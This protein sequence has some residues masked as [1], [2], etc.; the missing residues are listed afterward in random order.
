MRP[1]RVAHCA[2]VWLRRLTLVTGWGLVLLV[3]AGLVALWW[4]TATPGGVQWGVA[5]A[6]R[7]L[8]ALSVDEVTGTPWR[9]LRV[10]G[11]G[12]E[13]EEGASMHLE[14]GSL[15]IDPGALWRARL[16]IPE[17]TLDGI[18]L[19]LPPVTDEGETE[20]RG[21]LPAIPAMA[22]DIER[23]LAERVVIRQGETRYELAEARL[24]AQLE[25]RDQPPRVTTRLQALDLRLPDALRVNG[26]GELSVGLEGAIPVTARLELLIDHP[27]GWLDGPVTVAGSLRKGMSLRPRL[28][29]VGAD[30]ARAAV[31]GQ[32]TADAERLA[33]ES[34][35]VDALGGQLDLRGEAR[36]APSWSVDLT[37]EARSLDPTWIEPSLPGSLDFV[38]EAQVEAADG[39]LPGRGRVVLSDLQGRLAGEA[40][41]NVTLELRGDEARAS[42]RLSGTAAGGQLHFDGRLTPERTFDAE[43]QIDAL[44]VAMDDEARRTVRLASRGRLDG[45]LPDWR[46]E[47]TLDDWVEASRARLEDARLRLTEHVD[48][49]AERSTEIRLAGQLDSGRLAVEQLALAAPGAELSV[50]GAVQ[51]SPDWAR[52]R[53]E[54]VEASASVPNLAELPWDLIA[55]LPGVDPA[56]LRPQ[57]ARGKLTAMLQADG[58]LL[59]PHGRI[60]LQADR[61]RLAG[62]ALDRAR[63]DMRLDR[64]STDATS[65]DARAVRL[66]VEANGLRSTAGGSTLFDR[67]VVEADGRRADHRWTIELKDAADAGLGAHLEARGGWQEGAWQGQISRLT[68]E[69]PWAGG[70]RL[71][72]QA[73]L[74]LSPAAQRVDDLCL[75][76]M[77]V[78]PET[79]RADAVCLD[80]ERRD[81]HLQAS[82]Q[83]DLAL[84]DLWGQWRAGEADGA[85]FAGRLQ[86]DGEADI[87]G[88]ERT[89][90]LSLRLPASE[91]RLKPMGDDQAEP[92]VVTY[93]ETRLAATLAGERVEADLVGGVEDWL[94]IA[95]Q[96][97]LALGDRSVDGRLSLER[98][99]LQRL[100]ALVDR[101]F[102]P[103][104]SPVSELTGEVGGQLVLGG[105]LD[106]PRVS[107]R[108]SAQGLGFTSLSTGTSYEDGRVEVR[109]DQA[110]RL[111]LA[112]SLLGEADT[113]PK[114]VFEDKRITETAMPRSRG[115]IRL[116]GAGQINTLDDWRVNATLG[117]DAVPVLRL[118]S[119]ALDARPELEGEFTPSGGRLSGSIHVPLAIANV[120][121]LPENA[122]QNSEDLVIVGEEAE[123]RQGGYPLSGDINVLLGDAVSLRGQGLATRLTG[124]I[125]LRLRPQQPVGAFGEIR[126]VDGR[127]EAY[128]QRLSVERG[129]LI[130]AGPLTVPGLDVVATREIQDEAG[131]VV[132][133]Q[134]VGPLESPETEVFSRPPTS[135]SDALSLL[136]TGRRLSAGSDADAS[137]LLNAIAG[138]GI[139][140]G[141][142]MAQQV[143]SVFGIDE[144][145]FT[146]SG[147]AEGARLSVGKRIGENL[148]VRYAVGVFDGVGEVIT[149]YRIN[150]FL[151]LE[152]TSSAQSQSGDLIYQ[153]DRGRPEN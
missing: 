141:D 85:M 63:A 149:R 145:G 109:I 135:P 32:M 146:T 110:G 26:R 73:G 35:R 87:G 66:S 45:R 81:G 88:D 137:L 11:L 36:W 106:A 71:P 114:P 61:L 3:L 105:R 117:G 55:R 120:A 15:Q 94:T 69:S 76:P 127:Y 153:I 67:L 108:V 6:E 118:P 1:G 56:S 100:F 93:P 43:W 24:S 113:P 22:I 9:G 16:R 79:G 40:L 144:I 7:H 112:G 72:G 151:H 4:L 116:D 82:M 107:G 8:D 46:A 12:W 121:R 33:V 28:A 96:G 68:L 103:L 62:H 115:R 31:C 84:Q 126:L 143:K 119:L 74:L 65:L 101:L 102:G 134:I 98:A 138:L 104:R 133:L 37:G 10:A 75:A 59:A 147:G 38:L 5:Q 2:L 64:P 60:D 83:G 77:S 47:V 18:E 139:R 50:N 14:A 51:L 27:R 123:P 17:L 152:L 111:E 25:A 91:V 13:P 86:L 53:L 54:A 57:T 30:G 99:D 125:E 58:P 142:Q 39:W 70:W 90:G 20:T 42:A 21:E 78:T 130:F 122:R 150:K 148:L 44:P 129:R 41:D 89:A 124:G 92:E 23:L 132:G 52:W 140:Q 34:L 128:G 29:W 131:T 97:R 136:L 95:G 19:Q 49:N 48:G 80:A